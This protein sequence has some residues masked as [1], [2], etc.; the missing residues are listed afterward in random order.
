MPRY[1][2]LQGAEQTMKDNFL[3]ILIN[4]STSELTNGHF[5]HYK[6]QPPRTYSVNF[7]QENVLGRMCWPENVLIDQ[8][9]PCYT[10]STHANC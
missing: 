10:P 3:Y 2:N 4:N 8:P 5:G 6:L 1:L 7:T 9:I